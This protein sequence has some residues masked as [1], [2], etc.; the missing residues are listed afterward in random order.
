MTTTN[1]NTYLLRTVPTLPRWTDVPAGRKHWTQWRCDMGVP[2]TSYVE[3][4]TRP[5]GNVKLLTS[6]RPTYG[7]SLAPADI[8]AEWR[9]VI[10]A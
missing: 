7:L 6:E 3:W 9:K 4:L 2:T 10:P 1:L 5:E 8:S